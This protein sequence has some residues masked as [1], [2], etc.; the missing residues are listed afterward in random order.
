VE[1]LADI[2]SGGIA[3]ARMAVRDIGDYRR[4]VI[5]GY[6]GTQLLRLLSS[7]M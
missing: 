6:S 4:N 1:I 7:G 5:S 2:R 3:T